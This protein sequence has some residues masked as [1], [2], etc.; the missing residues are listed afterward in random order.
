[1]S[2]FTHEIRRPRPRLDD[3]PNNVMI[4]LELG[5]TSDTEVFHAKM[6]D[7]W[8]RVDVIRDSQAWVVELVET[9]EVEPK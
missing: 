3:D 9:M 8:S 4:D 5:N 2:E 6:R 7:L 1:M